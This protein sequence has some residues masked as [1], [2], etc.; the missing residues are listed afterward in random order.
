MRCGSWTSQP[1]SRPQDV[2]PDAEKEMLA[3]GHSWVASTVLARIS[4]LRLC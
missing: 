1:V 4:L 2:S 3:V